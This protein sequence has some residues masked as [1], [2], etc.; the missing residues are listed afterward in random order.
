MIG[1]LQLSVRCFRLYFTLTRVRDTKLSASL[2]YSPSRRTTMADSTL[3]QGLKEKLTCNFCRGVFRN[4]KMLPCFHSFCFDCLKEL[5]RQTKLFEKLRCPACHYGIHLVDVI[6]LQSLPSPYFISCLQKVLDCGQEELELTCSSCD[7]HTLATSFCFDCKCLVCQDCIQIHEQ[8]KAMRCHRII[9]LEDIHSQDMRE[10]VREMRTCSQK[11]HH[12]E[13]M[14]FFC[15]DCGQCVCEKC[16]TGVHQLHR[17]S[18]IEDARSDFE[19][20]DYINNLDV[21][22]SACK[23][24][25]QK[26]EANYNSAVLKIV[27]VRTNVR[28]NINTLIRVLRN[29]EKQMISE[30]ERIQLDLRQ[31]ISSHK[32]DYEAQLHQMEGAKDFIADIV[33]RDIDIEMLNLHNSLIARLDELLS[34]PLEQSKHKTVNI[35]YDHNHGLL[36]VLGK[37]VPGSSEDEFYRSIVLGS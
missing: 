11:A 36:Q 7:R 23:Y 25:I 5:Q 4:P 37:R 29:H 22:I 28:D 17:L 24:V 9:E 35:D 19:V 12:S 13:P 3:T 32:R 18:R 27:A 16:Q 15:H 14:A 31:D 2:N 21:K 30:L 6:A 1:N 34:V 20:G 8:M 26:I 10:L 33:D